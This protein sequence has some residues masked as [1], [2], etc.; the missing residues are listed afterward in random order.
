MRQLVLAIDQGT[1]S[2]RCI[3][4]DRSGKIT[5][6]AFVEFPQLYPRSGWVEHDPDQIFDSL[7]KCISGLKLDTA[8]D[9]I[10][11]IGIT[12]QRETVVAWDRFT[13]EKMHNA[14]VWLDVRT[15]D[16]VKKELAHGGVDKYRSVTGLPVSTYFSALKIRWLI[17]NVPAVAQ[18][19][20]N[21][22]CCFGTIDSYLTW[23]LTKGSAFVT[24]CANASRYNL[25][26]INS[27]NWSS[28]VCSTLGIPVNS[29][30][31]IVS[32]SEEVGRVH[33]DVVPILADVPITALIGDQHAALLGHAC[34]DLHSCKVTYGTGCFML[35]NTGSAPVES[36]SRSLLTTVGY[37]LGPNASP[38]YALEGSVATA[39]RALEWAKNNLHIANDVKEFNEIASSVPDSCGVTFVPAFSGLLSPYWRPDARAVIV[40]MSLRASYKHIAR[41]IFE[42]I[43]LQC[44]DVVKVMKKDA[45]LA[46]S[47]FSQIVTDGGMTKSSLLMQMQADYL[48]TV[49]KRAR[50]P[51]STAFGA[52]LCAG[53]HVGF[54]DDKHPKE[55][56]ALQSGYDEFFPEMSDEVRNQSFARWEDAVRRSFDLAR[57]APPE[58]Q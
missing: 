22:R 37:R 52:A 56:V 40:G 38:V 48:C 3:A 5:N 35:M 12:N 9:Q 44:A 16:L 18:G 58:D 19:L 15:E 55:I 45:D 50:M 30:P 2:T 6:S 41:S 7:I 51:E 53:M 36:R 33:G 8:N 29:L 32:N 46:D 10:A 34:T 20:A 42:S 24:D 54:W 28:S 25:M 27:L 17:D 31:R 49:V 47:E 4:F 1:T 57:F 23:R 14:L 21:N 43:A 26:D 11:A 39:G 13:G